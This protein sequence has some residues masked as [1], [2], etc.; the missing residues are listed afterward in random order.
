[1]N[2]NKE[3]PWQENLR[4]FTSV[5][6][7]VCL[8]IITVAIVTT[9]VYT[10]NTINSLDSHPSNLKSMLT[11]ARETVAN[12]HSTTKLLKAGHMEHVL[13]DFHNLIDSVNHLS[14]SLDKLHIKQVLRESSAWRNMST[15]TLHS[16]AKSILE[17]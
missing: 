1:M 15:H 17:L 10:I 9:G 11:D 12:I 16:I 5:V 2:W 7:A 13:T 14:T 6:S 4:T 8:V 3:L